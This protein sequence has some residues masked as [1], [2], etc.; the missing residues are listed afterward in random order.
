MTERG[1]VTLATGNIR[2]FKMARNML[3]SFRLHNPGVK[4]AI[5]CD[6]ENKYTDEFD[7]A[8][9]LEKTTG[10][11]SDKFSLLVH[12]PYEESIF[13]EPDCLIYRSLDYFWELLSGDSDFSCFG[14][15]TGGVD[16]WFRTPEA[17]ESLLKLVPQ[18]TDTE[19]V[20]LFNPGYFFIR[21]GEK[22]RKMYDD[23]IRIA[24]LISE[25]S[26]LK[27]YPP[28]LCRGNLRD[29]PVFNISMAINGF[30]CNSVPEKG[31]CISLPSKYTID[32]IDIR[33]GCLDVTDKLGR[34][35][36]DCALIHFST[37]KAEE[38]GF[39]L[40]QCVLAELSPKN[41][42]LYDLFN[43]KFAEV[44]FN[45]YRYVKTRFKWI[46]SYLVNFIKR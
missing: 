20:P 17:K 16:C 36:N 18:L 4:F 14:W 7:D 22:C 25:D 10:A 35:F 26:F 37:R 8:V 44:I 15:N 30:C 27:G 39:Y 6:K 9:V 2:Y 3:R 43:N 38:E 31:K 12:S 23:C 13:I 41:K 45:S 1:F 21:K 11:Y 29:D 32:R 33:K 5:V 42:F 46:M 28:I 34:K 40:W 24:K 19:N